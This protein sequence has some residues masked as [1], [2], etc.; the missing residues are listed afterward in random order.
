M[1]DR[2]KKSVGYLIILTFAAQLIA[3]M[4][5]SVFAYYYGTSSNADAY[6]MASQIPITLFAV[7]TTAINT[8]MLPIYTEKKERYG[9]ADADRFMNTFIIIFEIF[10]FI[11]S[12]LA[13]VFAR[14]I[15]FV[16]APY[17]SGDLLYLTIRYVR[18]LF[19]TIM[20]SSLINILTVRYYVQK[21]FAYTQYVGLLQN[22]SIIIMMLAFARRIGTDAPVLGTIIGLFLNALL[23]LIP[24]LDVVRAKIELTS[25]WH[26]VKTV[27]AKAIPVACGVGVAEI[28]RIVDKAIASGLEAGSITSINYAN[29]LCVIF[30]ALVVSAFSTVSFQKFSKLYVQGKYTE[31]AFELIRYLQVLFYILLPITCGVLILRKELITIVFAR[32]AF[33]QNAVDLTSDVFFYYALGIAPIAAREILSRYF[34]SCGDT[35]TPVV[36]S[37]VGVAVNIVLNIILSRIMGAPGLALATTVS[38]FIICL[39]LSFSFFNKQERTIYKMLDFI[40]PC[41]KCIFISMFMCVVLY[42]IQNYFSNNTA[43]CRLLLSILASGIFYIFFMSCFA[44]NQLQ[45]LLRLLFTRI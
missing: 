43:I 21:K 10:C 20:C 11:F 12:V 18:L 34:Y 16:F 39:M 1:I 8:V 38:Y 5:E 23:L 17:F 7:V 41:M 32:G 25:L 3:F 9:Q 13:C 35:K 37:A 19:P 28:N 27:L 33:L 31:Q 36:N 22:M 4:R 45:D 15:V 14:S 29:K 40:K 6:V 44:K 2:L 30:P 26:D 42:A 24:C